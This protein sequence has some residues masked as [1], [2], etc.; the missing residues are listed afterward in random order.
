MRSIH[1]IAVE[2][3]PMRCHLSIH[4][5]LAA[6]LASLIHPLAGVAQ[7]SCPAGLRIEGTVTDTTG[8]AIPGAR[9]KA[10]EGITATTNGA[11]GFVLPCVPRSLSTIT[12]QAEGFTPGTAAANG[13]AGSVV[14][15]SLQLP[16]AAVEASVQVNADASTID[17][18][19][20]AGTRTLSAQEI[21]Q[22]P[23]DPDDLLQQLQMLAAT[24]GGAASSAAVV[25]DGF[26]NGS[27]MPPKSSIASI[28]VN[29]DEF[30][31]EYERPSSHGGRIEITTKPG[32]ASF[33]GALFFNDSD[34]SFNATNP[35]SLISTPA[36][37]RRYG[38]ELSGPIL[39]QKS[40]FSLAL[41]KRDI[42]EFNIVN[43]TT[44]NSSGQPVPFQQTVTAPQRRW[45]ASARNDWQVTP[46]D[47]AT[48]SYT[49]DTNN[50]GNQG[51]GGLTLAEAGYSSLMN[52]YNLRFTNVMTLNPNLLHET[53]IGYTWNR[54]EQTP[55][56][57]AP[58]VQV[59]GYFVGGGATSQN[60]NDRERDL[61]IDDDLMVTRGKHSFK[62]GAQSL[63]L[64]IHNYD[65]DT[66]NGAYTFGGGSA[67]LL[68]ADN[69][70]TGQTTTLKP[71]EQYERALLHLPGGNATTYQVTNGNPLVPFTQ[72]RLALYAQD[73]IKL[74]PR[75]NVTTGIRYD[76]QTSPHS[77]A[78]FSPRVGI[79]WALDKQ[80]TWV[81]HLR[82]GLFSSSVAPSYPT[83]I[84]RLNGLRQQQTL[85]YSPD[86]SN[87]LTPIAGSIAIGTRWQFARSY[88]RIPSAQFQATLDHDLPH[89][90]H[91]SVALT[92]A[93]GWGDSR[94][95]NINAPQVASG[96]GG[97]PDPISALMAPRPFA[98]NQNIFEYQNSAHTWGTV[99]W[100]GIEQKSYKRFSLNLGY[101]AVNFRSDGGT[102]LAQPQSS[103]SNR[104]ESSRPDWQS[105]G[106]LAETELKLPGRLE[107]SAEFYL[108]T[109]LPYNL[110]TGTDANGDG[111]FN[112]RPSYAAAA[113]DGVYNTRFGL[114]STNT[115]NGNVPRNLGTMPHIL[116]A[117]ANLSRAFKL[118]PQDADHPS[119]LTFNVRGINV[120]NHTN[121]TAVGT[122]ISSPNLGEAITAEAA[123]R[124]ELGVRFAF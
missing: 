24:G 108:H 42:D 4:W 37:R 5:K 66:F 53:R 49:V 39:R 63:G 54:I 109:G 30:S 8:A 122:V 3:G 29:P 47:V 88:R 52:Q 14:Q 97:A 111:S 106:A 62:F 113:G 70:P 83:Q 25:V 56:S 99:F 32:P 23:D 31:P 69:Q 90:W 12:A 64:F 35:F 100:A 102:D 22:L 27:A 28:R 26:Q 10:S 59:A 46:R 33:H 61:E 7:E 21:Q 121:A 55:L 16:I 6:A 71:I 120:L 43:A 67:P 77:L 74:A 104:G 85:I 19:N 20:G 51:V 75:L 107:L 50:R 57:T 79:S 36:G 72:W 44:L 80:S 34:G 15:I 118:N 1:F 13:E 95:L 117:Y 92:W 40:G 94:S 84:Y 78:N 65:P 45:I 11:G 87:P 68:D 119:T 38:F 114:L 98:P 2:A 73:Q 86:Y 101:W 91:A 103:Y 93:D 81:M 96:S 17:A 105:S 41:E 48:F 60:L 124:V 89:H 58:S 76:L 82:A 123:R 9:V 115:V 18:D 116:H 110:T 112:D